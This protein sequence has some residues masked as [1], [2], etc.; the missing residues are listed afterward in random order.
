MNTI[1]WADDEME[2]LKP[3]VIYLKEKGYEVLSAT[4][5]QDAIDIFR[6]E[7][8]DIVFLDENMP[9][10]SGLETLETMKSLRADVPIVMITKSEEERIMEQAIGAKIADYLIKPVNPSQILL[11][12]KKHVHQREIVE[13]HTNKSYQEEFSDIGFMIDTAKTLDEWIAI[14]KTLSRWDIELQ[15]VDSAMREMLHMQSQQ[16]NAAFAKFVSRN[17]EAWFADGAQ[18]PLMSPDIFKNVLFP[19]LDKG[20]KLFF[21]VIDNFRYDQ[22][23]TIQPLLSEFFT[24]TEEACYSSIL[25]T[26]TQYARNAIF[27]GLMPLQIQEMFPNLWVEEDEEEG[28]NLNEKEL[29]QTQLERFRK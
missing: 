8:V 17:Y 10:L 11:C 15:D 9:G 19:M 25:P 20:E 28:K 29:I 18:R 27:S 5:G 13:K 21:V 16:A 6:N 22:W 1:L 23:K 4:N 7:V 24:T 2:L 12:L 14:Y 3:Y 26:A